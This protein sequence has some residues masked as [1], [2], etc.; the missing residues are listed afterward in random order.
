VI[1]IVGS[2]VFE[3]ILQDLHLISLIIRVI[4]EWAEAPH[5]QGGEVQTTTMLPIGGHV[6]D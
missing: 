1:G 4:T 3:P 6:S 2:E 5:D